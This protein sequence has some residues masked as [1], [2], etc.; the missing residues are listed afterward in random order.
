MIF[1]GE[2]ESMVP[3][4]ATM[5]P[6]DSEHACIEIAVSHQKLLLLHVRHFHGRFWLPHDVHVAVLVWC[7]W[8][9]VFAVGA[10]H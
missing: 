8:T 7:S 5:T 10:C 1:I 2:L 3:H 4:N 9:H 6:Y